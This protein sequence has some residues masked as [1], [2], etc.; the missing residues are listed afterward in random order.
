MINLLS[1]TAQINLGGP[2]S[3]P[4]PGGYNVYMKGGSIGRTPQEGDDPEHGAFVSS[5]DTEDDAKAKAGRMN[6]MLSP[7]EKKYYGIK[8]HVKLSPSV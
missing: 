5:H 4:R 2:G 1:R 3:G 8:Y 6:K 7:G